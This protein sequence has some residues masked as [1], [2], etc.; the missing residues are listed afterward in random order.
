[1]EATGSSKEEDV[2]EAFGVFGFA[3][4]SPLRALERKVVPVVPPGDSPGDSQ[5]LADLAPDAEL[6]RMKELLGDE[7]EAGLD[8]RLHQV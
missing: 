7:I 8:S 2:P 6:K 4:G 3:S 5:D 1:M